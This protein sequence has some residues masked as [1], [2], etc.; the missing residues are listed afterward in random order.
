MFQDFPVCVER[1]GRGQ[2][3]HWEHERKEH[4]TW[5][6]ELGSMDI[7]ISRCDDKKVG[8]SLLIAR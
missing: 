2:G 3:G 1:G 5:H 4:L 8:S 6:S 7:H